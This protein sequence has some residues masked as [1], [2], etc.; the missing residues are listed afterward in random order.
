MN[1]MNIGKTLLVAANLFCCLTI[2][3]E[4][5]VKA[6]PKSNAAQTTQTTKAN[7]ADQILKLGFF[8]YN[9]DDISDKAATQFRIVISKYP[10]SSEAE[11]AQYYL[12]SYYQRKYYVK[13]AQY[14]KEDKS[15]LELAVREYRVYTDKYYKSG[16]HKWL[17][18]AFF[19]L[20]LVYLQ[21][22]DAR[23][24][25]FELNK[26]KGASNLDSSVYIYQVIYSKN[27]EDVIDRS[28]ATEGLASYTSSLV[29]SGKSF[30]Q[31]TAS[32]KDWSKSGA[33]G[34]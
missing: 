7:T 20:A 8:Y 1:R 4:T 14:R 23:N 12:G 6:Q 5:D 29:Y 34:A 16:S 31:I 30:W 27:Y 11:T 24:A 22:G 2:F 17:G 21:K 26:M 13:W 25:G 33:K 3:V 32:I 19:N 18:D 28:V 9:N 10:K 15:P